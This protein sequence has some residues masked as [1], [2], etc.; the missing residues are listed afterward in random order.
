MG[1]I[2]HWESWFNMTIGSEVLIQQN[3]MRPEQL[4]PT[5]T[6]GITEV[7]TVTHSCKPTSV[8]CLQGKKKKRPLCHFDRIW[9]SLY[10]YWTIKLWQ[11]CC[12]HTP[13]P[14]HS[15]LPKR[16][17]SWCHSGFASSKT[18]H[19]ILP[20][21]SQYR[22][23]QANEKSQCV[24]IFQRSLQMLFPLLIYLNQSTLDILWNSV[25]YALSLLSSWRVEIS[26]LNTPHQMLMHNLFNA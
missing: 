6:N 14:Q 23:Y 18:D 17:P 8:C 21:S 20:I 22:D 5:D 2:L 25:K 7:F 4:L 3:I 26:L 15:A 16:I 11:R 1:L 9:I 24:A 10:L 19:E 12:P 13:L